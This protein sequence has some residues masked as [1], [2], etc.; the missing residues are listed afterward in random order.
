MQF[1]I[2]ISSNCL[3][4]SLQDLENRKREIKDLQYQVRVLKEQIQQRDEL[5][6]VRQPPYIE[7]HLDFFQFPYSLGHV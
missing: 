2:A 3:S 7:I 4:F 6:Q 5:I 1:L